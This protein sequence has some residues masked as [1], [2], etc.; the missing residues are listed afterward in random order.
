ME[1]WKNEK[2]IKHT[3]TISKMADVNPTLSVISVNVNGLNTLTKRQR[4]AKWI[5][6]IQCPTVYCL[7]KDRFQVQIHKSV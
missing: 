4:L 7:K 1:D 2:D 6:K 3:E 5:K